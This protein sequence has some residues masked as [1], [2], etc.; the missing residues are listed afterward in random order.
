MKNNKVWRKP[1]VGTHK[2][3]S[4][5]LLLIVVPTHTEYKPLEQ[6]GQR[7]LQSWDGSN[8]KALGETVFYYGEEKKKSQR[9]YF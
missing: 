5:I 4:F 2:L 6:S 7:K 1:L 3:P 8:F 9:H